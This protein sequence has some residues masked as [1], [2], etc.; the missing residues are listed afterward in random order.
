MEI[1]DVNCEPSD[2]I[3]EN[4]AIDPVEKLVRNLLFYLIIIG[5]LGASTIIIVQ[6]LQYQM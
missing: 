1:K 2:I 6:F 5:L 3:W 4:L